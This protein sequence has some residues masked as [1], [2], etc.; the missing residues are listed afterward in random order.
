MP[1]QKQTSGQFSGMYP[2]GRFSEDYPPER[3]CIRLDSWPEAD[4]LAYERAR[5]MGDVFELPGPAA[6]WAS[7]T[8]RGRRQAYG[9]YLNFLKRK[10]FLLEHEGPA[11]RM[12][13]E[14][15][16]L[17]L[18][19]ARRLLSAATSKQILIELR[20]ILRAMAP[21]K[22]WNWITRHPGRPTHVEVRASGKPKIAFDSRALCCKALDLMDLISTGL[23][24]FELRVLY[25]NALIVAIQCVFAL[26]RDNLFH[27]ELER[28]LIL[29]DDVI[30]IVFT[31]KETK[32]Y[33]P[34]SGV[35][36][37]FL[38]PYLFKWLDEHRPA[39]LSG[40]TSN[41]VWVNYRHRQL[42]YGASTFLFE[43][44]GK[45]FLGYPISCHDFRY[46][47]ATTI[48]TKDPRNIRMASGVLS[49]GSLRTVNQFY[50]QS[51]DAGSRR[52]WGK[53]RRDI[54]RGKG[55]DGP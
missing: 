49:H 51:G 19:E 14:R 17:Y 22:D 50:D 7:A 26:R 40:I 41:A 52:I 54:R 35:M 46:S 27:M 21:E 34:M 6:P 29:G 28:N 2:V 4:R 47:A 53:M 37:D 33:A 30:H 15:L 12:T 48:L 42:E 55:V 16:A 45:R 31:S 13:P 23:P 25:R 18:A 3:Q 20:L 24:S 32:N 10:G 38:K 1:N 8:C 43:T 11:D 39:L 5:Y 44:M 36:P 9:R